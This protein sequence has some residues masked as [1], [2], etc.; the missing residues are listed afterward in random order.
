MPPATFSE[1]EHTAS[2][3]AA[4]FL[5][6]IA[7]KLRAFWANRGYRAVAGVLIKLFKHD[8]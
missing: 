7:D 8:S 5:I 3:H 1:P 4:R 6:M 2:R